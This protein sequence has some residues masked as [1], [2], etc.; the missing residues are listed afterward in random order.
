MAHPQSETPYSW[1]AH[2]QQFESLPAFGGELPAMT[3][4]RPAEAR[5]SWSDRGSFAPPSAVKAFKPTEF[6]QIMKVLHSIEMRVEQQGRQLDALTRRLR[7][8]FTDA[9]SSEVI[10]RPFDDIIDFEEFDTQLGVNEGMPTRLVR[11]LFQLY[12]HLDCAQL[13]LMYFLFF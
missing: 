1:P 7:S 8:G 13:E 10:T 3:H 9:M 11:H 12:L 2:R 6:E 5:T 4:T